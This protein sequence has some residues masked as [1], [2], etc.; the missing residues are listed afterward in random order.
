MRSWLCRAALLAVLAPTAA[1]IIDI[2]GDDDPCYDV[3]ETTV[4]YRV[5]N[6]YT[7]QCEFRGGG[8]G[9][10]CYGEDDPVWITKTSP[11]IPWAQCDTYCEQL[12]EDACLVDPG[13]QAAYVESCPADT[14]C[15][16]SQPQFAGCWAI[17]TQIGGPDLLCEALE[18]ETCSAR[19]D[20]SPHY[21][22]AWGKP[23]DG[24]APWQ[25]AGCAS[26][27]SPQTCLADEE[28]DAGEHCNLD[29]CL[30]HPNCR[31]G[32]GCPP[33]CYGRCEPAPEPAC[34][35]IDCPP[36]THCE[37]VCA[38]DCAPTPGG[39]CD[40]GC[41]PVCVDDQ[42]DVGECY[43]DVLCDSLP[44]ACPSGT[45]AGVSNGCW[46]GYCIPLR[47][48][49]HDPGHCFMPGEPICRMMPPACPSGTVPGVRDMC[50]SGYCIPQH[51]C[52]SPATCESITDGPACLARAD[53]SPVYEGVD[54]TCD[55]SGN[56]TCRDQAFARC[57]TR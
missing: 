51:A 4:A 28:C 11:P 57:E 30:P 37:V 6:P 25:F 36:G 7:G 43:G 55:A 8:G 19:S 1:C 33:V 24:A 45:V 54:C 2:E 49:G 46:T 34:N 17:N 47:E 22:N 41:W 44:P 9:G 18:A 14:N 56:C 16:L 50:W 12:S 31:D 29:I 38:T 40:P 13:C 42:P 35:L 26:E 27:P 48:C 21:A 53:C 10:G 52:E 3:P 20:C 39:P 15:A 5:R 23:D 32:E